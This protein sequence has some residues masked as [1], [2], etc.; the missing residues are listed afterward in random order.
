[1]LS[2]QVNKYIY[3]GELANIVFKTATDG[4]Y[5]KNM[6]SSNQ[7]QQH[8]QDKCTYSVKREPQNLHVV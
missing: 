5:P 1:M 7:T 8:S 4:S 3:F 6:V 2:M